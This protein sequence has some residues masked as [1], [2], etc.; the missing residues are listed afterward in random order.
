MGNVTV[1]GMK[2]TG[3]RFAE[4][5]TDAK[6]MADLA[7]STPKLFGFHCAVV[8]FDVAIEAEVIG[9]PINFYTQVDPEEILYPTVKGKIPI[10]ANAINIP[11]DLTNAGRIPVVTEALRLLKED[12]GSEVPIGT[13]IMGPFTIAGQTMELNDLLKLCLKKPDQVSEI[14]D[15]YSGLVVRLAEIYFDAGADY[16]TIREMGACSDVL[17]PTVFTK[18]VEAH[19]TRIFAQAPKPLVLHICGKSNG[20][21]DSMNKCGA[22]ALSVDQKNDIGETRATIGAEPILF[23]NFDP[24]NILV[25]GTVDDV[26]RMVNGCAGS[27]VDALW[28]GCDIWPTVPKENMQALMRAAN[29]VARR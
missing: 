15:I 28:P 29:A 2:Q 5:H 10:D 20:I 13:Y 1:E 18:L 22:S 16:I 14:L 9:C 12:I 26:E 25:K 4:S 21:V 3:V 17:R 23:G 7:A 24:Y 27:G 6:M 19:L 8:P 11:D